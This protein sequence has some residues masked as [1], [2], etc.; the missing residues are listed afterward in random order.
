MVTFLMPG[1]PALPGEAA[2]RSRGS[3]GC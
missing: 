1:G 2:G 3:P